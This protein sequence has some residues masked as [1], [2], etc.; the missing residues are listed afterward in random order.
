MYSENTSFIG[1]KKSTNIFSRD[2]IRISALQRIKLFTGNEILA[3]KEV[4]QENTLFV[5]QELPLQTDIAAP[6][7]PNLPVP[8]IKCPPAKWIPTNKKANC[9]KQA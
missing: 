7:N 5:A 2:E 6:V 3:N 1:G 4:Q 9:G 8:F